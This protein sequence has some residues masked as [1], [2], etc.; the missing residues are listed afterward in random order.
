MKRVYIFSFDAYSS[1]FDI[2]KLFSFLNSSSCFINWRSAGLPGTVILAS[3]HNLAQVSEVLRNHMTG[4]QFIVTEINSNSINGWL[5]Q[6]LW[7]FISNPPEAPPQEGPGLGIGS[8]ASLFG[9]PKN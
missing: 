3:K 6:S 2:Q 1:A 7:D 5:N 9:P 8:L 4:R